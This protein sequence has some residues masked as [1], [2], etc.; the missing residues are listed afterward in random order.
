MEP[1]IFTSTDA[2]IL[3][4]LNIE[5]P[6]DEEL[7]VP[8]FAGKS[9]LM[10]GTLG[11]DVVVSSVWRNSGKASGDVVFGWA[12]AAAVVDAIERLLSF[13]SP[14]EQPISITNGMDK[15]SVS[16]SSSW[17]HNT[18]APLERVQVI[19]RRNY[20]LDG[21]ESH[22][23]EISL[24]PSQARKFADELRRVIDQRPQD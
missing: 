10:I 17:P 21:L 16:F 11:E 19:N 8:Q 14:W 9:K 12:N 4:E 22:I 13:E 2:E 5:N 24:P 7:T 23:V 3:A 20:M 1:E 15:L 18:T 6:Y